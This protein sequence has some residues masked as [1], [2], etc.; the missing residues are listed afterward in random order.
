[1]PT[2]EIETIINL[3]AK[4]Q[5]T[6]NSFKVTNCEKISCEI[7]RKESQRDV[8]NQSYLCCEFIQ[9][10]SN[11]KIGTKSMKTGNHFI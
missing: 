7:K 2:T 10:W 5:N 4:F 6:T 1:M 3:C 8:R 11:S 9:V